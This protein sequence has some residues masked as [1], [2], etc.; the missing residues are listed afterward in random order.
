MSRLI[1]YVFAAA[2]LALAMG[3][4]GAELQ[5]GNVAPASGRI[6]LLAEGAPL[7]PTLGYLEFSRVERALGSIRVQAVDSGAR[8]LA[9]ATVDMQSASL[10]QPMLV[11]TGNGT[12]EPYELHLYDGVRDSEGTPAKAIDAATIALH[13]LAPYAGAADPVATDANLIC[14]DRSANGDEGSTGTK[15]LTYLDVAT[16]PY[17]S[18]RDTHVCSFKLADPTFGSFDLSVPVVEGTMRFMMVGDGESEPFRVL[19]LQNGEVLRVAE[20]SAPAV[21]AVTRSDDFWYDLARPAQGVGLY[22]I[23]GGEDIFGTWFTHDPAGKPI[24]Y[25]FDGVATDLPGQRELV[26][27]RP[28]RGEQG[29]VMTA[30]GSARLFYL[31]CNQAELRIMLGEQDFFTLR[32]RRSRDVA[33]CDALE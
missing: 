8:V 25:F 24:W 23:P 16:L 15:V 27:Y 22:E 7:G 13:H 29:N 19:I 17:T 31:D 9:E 30:V 5:V 20:Q 10:I 32:I 3:A 6:Q 11:L 2:A 4:Q 14:V 12:I 28:S 33:S 26:L 1:R 21:G 18:R